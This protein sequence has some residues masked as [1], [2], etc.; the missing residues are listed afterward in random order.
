MAG[1]GRMPPP[2][3]RFLP[4]PGMIHEPFGPGMHPPGPHPLDALPPELLEQRFAIQH[5]EMQRLAAE[6][7]RLAATHVALRQDLAISQQEIQRMH[8]HMGAFQNDKEQQ[9]RGLMDKIAKMEADLQ[10]TESMKVDLQQA[11]ADAQSLMTMRQ[12]LTAQVQELNLELQ[13]CHADVQQIPAMHAEL[14]SLRQEFQRARTAYDYEKAANSEQ[15]QQL[16]SMEKNFISMAREV[17]RL[18]AELANVDKR[19]SAAAYGASF[20]DPDAREARESRGPNMYGDGYGIPQ[21][22][23]AP[24]SGAAY[25]PGPTSGR[26]GYDMPRG[27]GSQMPVPPVNGAP[28]GSGHTPP[29]R[30]G[31]DV[32]RSGVSH[33]RR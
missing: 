8:A 4:G 2:H 16:Q 31:Y 13:R 32:P 21:M 28:Y 25:G 14:D 19:G 10:A 20:K 30:V 12:E 18:R 29:G 23:V 33:V 1:R 22:A 5:G 6:N 27:G 26:G 3:A 7:Q 9:V 24:G 15:V 17:E 11:R